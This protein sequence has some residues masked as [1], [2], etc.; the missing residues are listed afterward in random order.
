MTTDCECIVIG[1]GVVGLAIAARLAQSGLEVV[2]L[3]REASYGSITSARN[4]EVIHAGIYYAADSL[5]A[6]FCVAG[7]QTLYR[8]C[9]DKH[10]RH[11][12]CGKLIVATTDSQVSE[13]ASIRKHAQANGVADISLLS[14]REARSM[15]PHLSC[16]AALYSPSTGIIDTQDLMLNLL[17]DAESHGAVLALHAPVVGIAQ[18]PSGEGYKL[19]VGG[20]SEMQLTSKLVINAAGLGACDIAMKL[21]ALPA[22]MSP[23]PILAKGNYFR[24]QGKAPFSRLIY[25]VPEVGGLGVHIT[26]D[27][28]GQARFGPDVEPVT[29]VEYSVDPTRSEGF[30]A[31]VRRYWPGLPDDSLTPDYAGIR[32]KIRW[33]NSLYND[34]LITSERDH[35]LPGLVNLFGMESPGLTSCLAIA[36]HV[37][38][39]L[40]H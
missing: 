16:L 18:L 31:A 40:K 32:P 33:Q 9:Q 20:D 17:G 10:I 1:A 27:L 15:E 26:I 25:P 7:K 35:G 37:K 34:F 38:Q 14:Q 39:V 24:L 11:D 30:Y 29:E 36:E 28:A 19:S 2:V 12:Q 4:S 23:E 21:A 6:Q 5:K 8:Y 22:S 3:D 13:L